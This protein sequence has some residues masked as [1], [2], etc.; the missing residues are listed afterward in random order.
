[1]NERKNVDRLPYELFC[2]EK[3]HAFPNIVSDFI[4]FNTMNFYAYLPYIVFFFNSRIHTV[5]GLRATQR[6][7]SVKMIKISKVCD[8]NDIVDSK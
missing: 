6:I 3:E 1:M 2:K 5:E 4:T 7:A 8:M